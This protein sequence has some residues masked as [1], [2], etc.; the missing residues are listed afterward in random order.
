MN[1]EKFNN[2]TDELLV[3]YLTGN[4]SED[5]CAEAKEWIN[6][7]D[8]NRK[9]F[10]HLNF[11]YIAAKSADKAEMPDTNLVW[12]RVKARHYKNAAKKANIKSKNIVRPDK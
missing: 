10:E 5:E 2:E 8:E 6:K 1:S 3:K 11:V 4:A 12:E 9:Y 7:S